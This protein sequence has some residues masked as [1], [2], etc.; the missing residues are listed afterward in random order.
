MFFITRY[1]LKIVISILNHIQGGLKRIP[2]MLA[3]PRTHLLRKY[4]RDAER[5][6]NG[7]AEEYLLHRQQEYPAQ[8]MLKLGFT[9]KK[10][11]DSLEATDRGD[12][13][14]CRIQFLRKILHKPVMFD[15]AS[16]SD[17]SSDTDTARETEG[18]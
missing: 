13:V 3:H 9:Y 11:P 17:C 8:T 10:K 16:D 12:V 14:I 1:N 6:T 2:I 15:L 7:N 18:L 4:P 5:H